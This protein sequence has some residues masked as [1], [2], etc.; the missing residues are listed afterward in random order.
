[1]TPTPHPIPATTPEPGALLPAEV[2]LQGP[3]PPYAPFP[4]LPGA[5]VS[6]TPS[7]PSPCIH[8][9]AWKPTPSLHPLIPELHG[10]APFWKHPWP[11]TAANI[12]YTGP[13]ASP[14]LGTVC[15]HL[16]ESPLDQP[17][18]SGPSRGPGTRQEPSLTSE[19]ACVWLPWWSGSTGVGAQCAPHAPAPGS[20]Q[21]Q[22]L[23]QGPSLQ[24]PGQQAV[25]GG[26][27]CCGE[28]GV[29]ATIGLQLPGL[30]L[31]TWQPQGGRAGI[32]EP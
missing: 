19:C 8:C 1:M 31:G 20:H 4:A 12:S 2:G 29:R 21:L 18:F 25:L 10:G 11:P 17:V 15:D 7:A 26:T 3:C 13:S 30:S 5:L 22:L 14:I 16:L 6:S 27:Q 28:V 24:A 23:G 9:S 32:L